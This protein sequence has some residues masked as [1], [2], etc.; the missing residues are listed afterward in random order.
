MISIII[1]LYNKASL[2]GRAL[3][4]ILS[5]NC[6]D[7]EI[8]VV[9]DGSTDN[10][11]AI[12]KEFADAHGLKNLR[13]ISQD[14]AGVGAARNRGISEAKGE[15]IT[16]LDADDEWKSEHLSAL[17]EL[18]RRYPH[19]AVFATNYENISASGE[20]FANVIRHLSFSDEMGVINNYFEIAAASNPPLWTSAVMARTDALR[21]IGGF[22]EGIK[23]GEDL[24]TW[25]RLAANYEIAY[26]RKVSAIYHRG[27][28]NPRPPEKIDLLG[29]EFETLYHTMVAVKFDKRNLG[30]R[31]YIAL[32]Y[33]MRMSRCLAHRMY[34]VAF[35]A[36]CKSLRYRPTI[37]IAKPLV[38]FTLIG[39]R[40]KN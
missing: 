27:S 1:P 14:N 22:P 30:L 3:A 10:G 38:K 7:C 36:L 18:A 5:Q 25:A 33:N 4:S 37:R 2:I 20:T 13:I 11:A 39:L 16:F 8:I 15:F 26:C 32:W 28:S 21:S 19:C 9:N 35:K 12:V 34:G 29:K 23:S 31:H 17:S 40:R 24:L 6:E